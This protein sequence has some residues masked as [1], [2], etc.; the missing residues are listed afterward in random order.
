MNSLRCEFNLHT[1]DRDPRNGFKTSKLSITANGG[2]R[3][4]FFLMCRG[5][6]PH[7]KSFDTTIK[8]VYDTFLTKTIHAQFAVVFCQWKE[9]NVEIH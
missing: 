2:L 8:K 4:D 5:L 6:H 7:M 9:S 3:T 1:L